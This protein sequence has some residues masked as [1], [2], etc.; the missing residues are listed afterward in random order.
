MET[1]EDKHNS[2]GEMNNNNEMKYNEV[3]I[4]KSNGKVLIVI[5]QLL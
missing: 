3:A 4:N 2:E 1:A 5:E